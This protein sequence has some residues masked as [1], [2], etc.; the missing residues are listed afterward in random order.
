MSRQA[1]PLATH[2]NLGSLLSPAASATTVGGISWR[3]K[4]GLDKE[5]LVQ[6]RIAIKHLAPCVLRMTVHPLRPS[7]PFL[8]YLVGAGR[9][10]FSARRLCVNHTHRPIE[11]THKHRTEP[12]IGDEVAYK[13]TDIP[14]VPLAPRV[15]PGV[16]RAI[17]EAFAAE[18]FVE[19]G[20]DFTWVEP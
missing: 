5:G 11:G 19:L 9:D 10:G 1:S 4:P 18:C 8:Q 3:Q 14:E 7:E 6:V 2:A 15:A 16:H 13:P 12:A 20:T 17:F